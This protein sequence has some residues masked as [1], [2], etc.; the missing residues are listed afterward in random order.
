M[1]PP[2][3]T[4]LVTL[5]LPGTLP[6]ATTRALA[7]DLRQAQ[8]TGLDHHRAQKAFFA[9]FDAAL[10]GATSGPHYFE[11]EKLADALAGEIMMLEETGFVVHGFAI[12]PGHAHLVLH[13]PARSGLA[14][15]KALDL[16]HQRTAAVCR[17]LVRP[18]LPP[19]S[20]F[21]QPGWHDL[22]VADAAELTRVLA[23]VRGQA[24]QAGLPQ[25][26]QEWPYEL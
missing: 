16:L 18:K 20:P 22:P 24:R 7:A 21:W 23:Y 25:R 11:N 1:L 2:G 26:F 19:E 10:D 9:K 17:R 13:L 4:V 14:L 3:E 12:L 5:R 8:A 6:A 15:A